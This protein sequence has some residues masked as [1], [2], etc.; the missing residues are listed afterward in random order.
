MYLSILVE[1]ERRQGLT[2]AEASFREAVG[3]DLKNAA[4][5]YRLGEFLA[6]AARYSVARTAQNTGVH[7]QSPNNGKQRGFDIMRDVYTG[8]KTDRFI[9]C[10]SSN[11]AGMMAFLRTWPSGHCA[12][13]GPNWS[14]QR[15]MGL[16]LHLSRD[17]FGLLEPL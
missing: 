1:R 13:I 12:L 16:C 9:G 10:G 3:L 2:Q 15:D 4:A 17:I 14:T 5:C 11:V 7:F 6:A 8:I